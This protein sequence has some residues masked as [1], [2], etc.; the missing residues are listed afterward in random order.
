MLKIELNPQ[1]CQIQSRQINGQKGPRTIHE[2]QAYLHTGSAYPIPFKLSIR[3]PADAYPS[4]EYTL[5][6]DS[7]TVNQ[8]GGLEINRFEIRLAPYK[9]PAAPMAAAK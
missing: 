3:T 4:G 5:H 8:F 1:D 6:P 9:A 2:Q 7:F